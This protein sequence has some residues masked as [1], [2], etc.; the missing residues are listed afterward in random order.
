MTILEQE[1]LK[2][3]SG[4]LRAL[5]EEKQARLYKLEKTF[6]SVGQLSKRCPWNSV[7]SQTFLFDMENDCQMGIKQTETF[8]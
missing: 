4:V 3:T 1:S 6:S 2:V 8:L 7:I 5:M